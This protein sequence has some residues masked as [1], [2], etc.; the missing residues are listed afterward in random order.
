VLPHTQFRLFRI[1]CGVVLLATAGAGKVRAQQ[2]QSACSE[3]GISARGEPAGYRWLALVKARGNW[4]A[5][6]RTTQDMGAAY[7]DWSA[8]RDQVERCIETAG[9]IVCTVTGIPCRRP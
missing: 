3:T 9:S 1:L 7:A 8:A 5:R 2:S 4:R 6:V